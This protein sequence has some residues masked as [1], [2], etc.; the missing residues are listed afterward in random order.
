L[1]QDPKIGV[2]VCE[3]S[4]EIGARIRCADLASF[5]ASLEGVKEVQTHQAY[6]M[7]PGLEEIKKTASAQGLDRVVIAGCS[8]RTHEALF[9]K[10]LSESNLN[11][12]M[13]EVVNVRD[14]AA[15]VTP[16]EESATS[17][18]CAMLKI[19][20]ARA[21]TLVPLEN[22]RVK[23]ERRVIV[24][25]TGLAGLTVAKEL[26]ARGFKILAVEKSEA[27]G[28][29][30][31]RHYIMLPGPHRTE[32]FLKKLID[33]LN[34][35]P[36][37]E[38]Q[39]GAEVTSLMGETGTYEVTVRDG[40]GEKKI[41]AGAVV[42]AAGAEEFLPHGLF[43]FDGGDVI[44]QSTFE[45][46]LKRELSPLVKSIAMIQCAGGRSERVPYCSRIC[47]MTAL[48]NAVWIKEQRPFLEISIIFRDLY[49]GGPIRERDIKTAAE[50]GIRFFRYEKDQPPVVQREKEG[51]GVIPK[52]K[53]LVRDILTNTN[54][55][56]ACDLVVLSNPL[57][58]SR[59]SAKLG[60]I[61]GLPVDCYGF[62]IDHYVRVKPSHFVEKGI[63]VC[64]NAHFPLS[65]YECQIQAY[66][67]ASRIASL[68]L[69]DELKGSAFYSE[70]DQA[71]CIAC[72]QC[73]VVCP[74]SAIKVIQD[75]KGKK[76][77]SSAINCL[78]CGT[79]AAGCPMQAISMRHFTDGQL[80]SQIAAAAN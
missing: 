69:Q 78:G 10:A 46:L 68:L 47:C 57:V 21:G 24:I 17:K 9:M 51:G 5:A 76:A 32:E 73:E 67:T 37:V 43:G 18:A 61:L 49:T 66:G 4:G 75:D 41:S 6:C 16:S 50:K 13:L 23:P 58:P 79:C 15:A 8:P 25:G 55:E 62:L 77:H 45:S 36:D 48:K 33:D 63:F 80:S 19:A 65:P 56:L 27:A 26:T 30:L 31:R 60:D 39:F 14:H 29:M 42:V 44:T 59:D 64:G 34:K 2:F 11:P 71:K 35:S 53:V 28:G 7:P 20:V 40:S 12:Y 22:A 3:C 72:G 1:N 52:L 38:F 74:Y 54:K 70:I